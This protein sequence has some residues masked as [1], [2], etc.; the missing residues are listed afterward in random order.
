MS[1]AAVSLEAVMARDNIRLPESSGRTL[2]SAMLGAGGA[3]VALAFLLVLT[4]GA[5]TAKVVLHSFHAGMLMALGFSLGSLVFVMI[6]HQT[7]AG[8]SATI[9]R[10]FENMMSLVWV[11]GLLYLAG[12]VLQLV[13]V[14][15]Y[16]SGVDAP[17]LF[18][19]M[20]SAYVEGD[21][22]YEHKSGFLNTPF[23]YV[24][25]VV[26]FAVWL[27]LSAALWNYST[28]QDSDGDKW[29]TAHARKLSAI[30]LVLFAFA[31]AFAGFDWMMSLDFHWFSTMFGVYFFAGCIVSALAL[32]TLV[33]ILLR[34]FG[35]I[36]VAFTEEHLHDL[37]KLVF[38]FTVF[39][40]YI[41]FSQYFLIW[42]A[43]IPEET[44][45]IA[46]RREGPW[47]LF[48]WLIPIGHFIVP[49]IFLMA[50]TVRRS[51][52]LMVL[53]CVWVLLMHGVDW[54]WAIRPEVK[55]VIEEGAKAVSIG[56]RLIDL[57]AIAGPVLLFLGVLVRKIGA[58][59]LIPLKDPRLP[60]ALIHKNY[61]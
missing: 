51:F 19:W 36:H 29:H 37:G 8:W 53:G 22:L 9:R 27:G 14:W 7:N 17:Y 24:R 30:G 23:F 54:Y 58:G 47:E 60:E 38:A 45:W 56:P 28:R 48:S 40:A 39:W 46:R 21:L 32:G 41:A 61:V 10:Q 1:G 57:L 34:S 35:R 31:T 50:R 59:P 44:A 12:V 11:G 20:N 5:L 3:L 4:G 33:L 43:N 49:F 52:G 2:S 18:N 6:L 55:G 42:Y 16:P 26:Y 13:A 25:A 15:R